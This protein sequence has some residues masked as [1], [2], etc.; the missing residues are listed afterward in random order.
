MKLV[1]LNGNGVLGTDELS[2]RLFV[3][4]VFRIAVSRQAK[5]RTTEQRVGFLQAVQAVR[6][7]A[8]R[9]QLGHLGYQIKLGLARL[10][11]HLT[12]P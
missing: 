5:A 9:K 8:A 4:K 6:M 7:A 3:Q 12:R 1:H 10:T 11:D 2:N